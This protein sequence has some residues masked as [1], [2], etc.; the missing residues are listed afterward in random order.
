M[1]FLINQRAAMMMSYPQHQRA[2]ATMSYPQPP[3]AHEM[4]VPPHVT[5]TVTRNKFNLMAMVQGKRTYL[6]ERLNALVAIPMEESDPSMLS[7]QSKLLS[8]KE[9]CAQWTAEI[10]QWQY[11]YPP[12]C[13]ELLRYLVGSGKFDG[14]V[15]KARES[16][17]GKRTRTEGW[18]AKSSKL[19]F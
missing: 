5:L 16:V 8:E 1:A 10:E 2:D 7:V 13:M 11:K 4:S 19:D 12:F 6:T 9:K 17:G 3:A 14:L 18:K 15:E